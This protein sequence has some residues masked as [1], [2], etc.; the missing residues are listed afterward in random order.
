MKLIRILFYYIYSVFELLYNVRN[1][2]SL[3]PIFLKPSSSGDHT[4]R[5]RKQPIRLRLRGAMDVWAVKETFLDALYTRYGVP[6]QDRWT[7]V[8]IGAGIGDFSIYAAFKKPNTTV[9]AFEPFPESYQLLIHNLAAN[10]INNVLPFQE[11]VW[12]QSGNLTLDLSGG[13]P[14]QITSRGADFDSNDVN[15]ITVK[16]ITLEDVLL[17]QGMKR[18][19]LLKLDCEGA[20][21][22]ILMKAPSAVLARIDRIVMEY[23]D[24]SE[25][26]HH[27]RL[28]PFLEDAGY[29]V[30]HQRNIVHDEIGY[31]FAER[32]DTL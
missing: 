17:G 18:V 27:Q 4:I 5:L 13:E 10:D 19:D 20:E 31:L 26:C 32:Q 30:T 2:L 23:H 3:I 6:V 7:V 28:I 8:D 1:W 22:D 11:A 16:A 24:V 15:F 9:Y 21:Y 12:S 14:L 25:E 29:Q